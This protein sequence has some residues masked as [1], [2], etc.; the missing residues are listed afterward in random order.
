MENGEWRMEKDLLNIGGDA[1]AANLE[2][3]V[4]QRKRLFMLMRIK[5]ENSE[6][7]IKELDNQIIATQAEMQQEDVA[8]VEKKVAELVNR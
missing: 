5:V 2:V 4:E 1:M 6:L 8:W 3:Q 7:I